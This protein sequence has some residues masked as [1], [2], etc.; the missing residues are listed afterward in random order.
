M[1]QPTGVVQI[2]S[3]TRDMAGVRQI[4]STDELE[5]LTI[6]G[7]NIMC[8]S[9]ATPNALITMPLMTLCIVKSGTGVGLYINTDAGTTWEKVTTS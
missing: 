3:D 9:G 2:P 7:I 8:Y 5:Y 4:N 6:M 1:A